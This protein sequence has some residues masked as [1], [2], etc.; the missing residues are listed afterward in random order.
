MIKKSA[1]IKFLGKLIF[2]LPWIKNLSLSSKKNMRLLCPVF[3][4]N[5]RPTYYIFSKMNKSKPLKK[6]THS[7]LFSVWQS[8]IIQ[9]YGAMMWHWS[10][11]WLTL[12]DLQ[13]QQQQSWVAFTQG[14]YQTSL[15]RC[16]HILHP[17]PQSN[18]IKI[19]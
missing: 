3:K 14:H 17:P 5:W 1:F 19:I 16:Q 13:W 12:W 18:K 11:I 10:F 15:R 4:I 2:I 7:Q 8:K 9:Q 6:L